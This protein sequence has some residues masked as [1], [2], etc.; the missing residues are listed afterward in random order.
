MS[1]RS[2]RHRATPGAAY[3]AL[4]MMGLSA[5]C[6]LAACRLVDAPAQNLTHG[7]S[8]LVFDIGGA[9]KEDVDRVCWREDGDS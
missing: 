7:W 1:V 5:A 4:F 9:Y 2:L 3:A 8:R 6:L